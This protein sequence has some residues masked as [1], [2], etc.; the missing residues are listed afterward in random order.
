MGEHGIQKNLCNYFATARPKN[1]Y[2]L[3]SKNYVFPISRH[4][5]EKYNLIFLQIKIYIF[6][7]CYL[8]HSH[9]VA[10]FLQNLLITFSQ[11]LVADTSF[12]SQPVIIQ[13]I[14]IIIKIFFCI[15]TIPKPFEP[16]ALNTL[17]FHLLKQPF[18]WTFQGL[19]FCFPI[20]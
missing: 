15:F 8:V 6:P 9:K 4:P 20:E 16:L 12:P 19:Y 3:S 2:I 14:A 11:K 10:Y 1:I 18:L 13:Q 17:Y 7:V 5:I